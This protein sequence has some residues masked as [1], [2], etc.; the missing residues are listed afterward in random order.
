MLL[1]LKSSN[2]VMTRTIH[3]HSLPVQP[4]NAASR[5]QNKA[6]APRLLMLLAQERSNETMT[7]TVH[8]HFKVVMH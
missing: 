2:K 1:A 4:Q 7:K 6:L 3:L 8:L 5:E